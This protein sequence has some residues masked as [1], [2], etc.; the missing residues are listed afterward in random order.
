MRTRCLHG[1]DGGDRAGV[2]GESG[3]GGVS[4]RLLDVRVGEAGGE[5]R[6]A[7]GRGRGL[8]DVGAV[9]ELALVV[10][11]DGHLAERGLERGLE[12]RLVVHERLPLAGRARVARELRV[13]LETELAVERRL[14]LALVAPRAGE[15]RAAELGLDEELSVE[16]LGCRVEGRP[17][18]GGVDVV[19]GRDGVRGEEGNDLSSG[20]AS[21]IGEAGQDAVDGVERL[22]DGQVGG[23]LGSVHT[24][25]E[26][27]ELR[28][29]GAVGDT[30]GA[31][32]LDEVGGGDVVTL[33]ERPLLVDDLVDTEVGVEVGLDVLEEGDGTVG[34]S[35]SV[36]SSAQFERR[37][38]KCTNPN[39]PRA[40]MA[41]EIPM[42]SWKVRRRDSWTS[43]PHSPPSNRLVWRSWMTGIRTQQ[44]LLATTVPSEQVA[45]RMRAPVER[46]EKIGQFLR[47][48]G[49]LARQMLDAPLAT[50][51]AARTE[52]KRA[53][54][55]IS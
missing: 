27:V 33:D 2:G 17:G 31:G 45:R 8:D 22:R 52:T 18:D 23:G 34:A 7:R 44:A 10:A 1:G 3:E 24:A 21:S 51:R 41:G 47:C 9:D 6:V 42:A 30:D 14:D 26:D 37:A 55:A 28:S 36:R 20:E 32:E 13:G 46:R 38:R 4:A 11:E 50:W 25:K 16:E 35:T 53:V 54:K 29:T 43:S 15:E 19:G 5:V 40:A 49:A 39:W 12:L 48:Q